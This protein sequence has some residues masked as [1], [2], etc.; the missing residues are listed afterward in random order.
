PGRWVSLG[1]ERREHLRF[2]TRHVGAATSDRETPVW[3][4]SRLTRTV[5]NQEDRGDDTP[6]DAGVEQTTP[7]SSGT[8]MENPVC[9]P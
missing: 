1:T 3:V 2:R 5:E 4:P 8:E 7:K 6:Q 9:L